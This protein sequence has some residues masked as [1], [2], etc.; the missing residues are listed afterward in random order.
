MCLLICI[1]IYTT[2]SLTI[3]LYIYIYYITI[4]TVCI[5][6]Y[7]MNL[8]TIITVFCCVCCVPFSPSDGDENGDRNEH[9]DVTPEI[10][11]L[12][13]WEHSQGNLPGC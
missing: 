12:A 9:G 13:R 3:I 7:I 8:L 4:F 6:I 10:F 5:Y 1:Y 11:V 2:Y